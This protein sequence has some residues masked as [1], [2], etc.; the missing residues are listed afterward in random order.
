MTNKQINAIYEN[1]KYPVDI[2]IDTDTY[3]EIDDQFAI[4]YALANKDKINIKGFTVAPFRKGGWV[5][6]VPEGL[7]KSKQEIEKVVTLCNAT[8]YLDKI[9][10]GADRFLQDEKTPVVTP[11]SKFIVETSKNYS[12]SNPLYICAIG[13]ITN[14]A[15]AILMDKTIVDR[16]AVIWLGGNCI[17]CQENGEYNLK[18]DVL[19]ARIVMKSPLPFVHLSATGV[20]SIFA[21]T[22]FELEHWLKN[23]NPICDYLYNN[24]IAF[25]QRKNKVGAWSKVIWDAVAVAW[26]LN[27][28]NRFMLG[29]LE[30]KYM[31]SLTDLKYQKVHKRNKILYVYAIKRDALM[32][33]LF[34][35]LNDF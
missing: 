9:F 7:Q 20:V 10:V 22:Q 4:A 33:D 29:R 30:S 31:P 12:S 25:M 14:V 26:L 19:S 2:I 34:T 11:A 5:K 27:E 16:I 32:T 3:N 15:S 23:K 17:N 24:C 18:Q 28:D 6:D 21:T 1:V 35:K 8:E 13:A